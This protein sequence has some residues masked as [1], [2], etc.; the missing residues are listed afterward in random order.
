MLP[1][2]LNCSINPHVSAYLV[3]RQDADFLRF[4]WDF[5]GKIL[6]SPIFP[7]YIY[8][9]DQMKLR[10]C[11]S[12]RTCALRTWLRI[13]GWRMHYISQHVLSHSVQSFTYLR[14]ISHI[15]F[16]FPHPKEISNKTHTHTPD[17]AAPPDRAL[18]PVDYRRGCIDPH[19]HEFDRLIFP[20]SGIHDQDHQR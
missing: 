6:R 1:S 3:L 5:H 14:F 17:I 11:E 19:T 12:A 10:F 4:S 13:L 18:A 2:Q 15:P 9:L 8:G 16:I 20:R 7:V